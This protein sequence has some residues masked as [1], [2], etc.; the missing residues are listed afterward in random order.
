MIL[1]ILFVIVLAVLSAT[2]YIIRNL[3]RK[4]ETYEAWIKAYYKSVDSILSNMK[5]IDASGA[6]E[7]DD[8][9]GQIFRML[10]TQVMVLEQFSTKGIKTNEEKGN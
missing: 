6:F 1:E 9:V 2:I 10:K 4:L 3:N 7:S 8:E 5:E